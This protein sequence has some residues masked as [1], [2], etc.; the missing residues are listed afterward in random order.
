MLADH[1]SKAPDIVR[2]TSRCVVWTRLNF[3]FPPGD[4]LFSR[5]CPPSPKHPREPQRGYH[6]MIFSVD[7]EPPHATPHRSASLNGLEVVLVDV[8]TDVPPEVR[9]FLA[10][11]A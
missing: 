4:Q 6:S 8:T 3:T 7:A 11:I 2:R 9:A 10:G 5:R 1:H